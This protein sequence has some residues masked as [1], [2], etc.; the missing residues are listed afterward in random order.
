MAAAEKQMKVLITGAEGQLGNCL[1]E[2]LDLNQIEHYSMSR[3]SM[4]ITD[5]KQV[6]EKLKNIN[7]DVTINCAAYTNVE[8]AEA[9]SAK[10]FSV[11]C[12]G[13]RNLAI[14]S[15]ENNSKLIHF[16]TDYVFS[17]NRDTP[18]EVDAI[19]NPL[20]AYGKSKLAGELAIMEEYPDQSIIIRTSWLYSKFGKN[21]YKT[22]LNLALKNEEP[23]NVVND[24]FGQPTNCHDLSKCVVNLISSELS[25][26]IYHITNSGISTW[27]DFAVE[28]FSLNGSDID[29]VQAISSTRLK[30]KVERPAYSV[31]D[32]SKFQELSYR[33][34]PYWK[35]SVK[36]SF[37]EIR[38][39]VLEEKN[40]EL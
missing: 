8:Q 28:I 30:T 13:A 34:M 14:A 32:N 40:Y 5:I 37:S 6:K 12:S 26:N 33:E 39:S 31:L 29:R 27:F 3:E 19:A 35:D 21:F 20:S 7:P 4:N 9:E 15:R 25:G 23:V 18:W 36:K 10:A 22:I 2:A 1:K 11:N 16:S 17:G 38:K 24:Q